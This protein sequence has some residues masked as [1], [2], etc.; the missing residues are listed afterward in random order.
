MKVSSLL[1]NELNSLQAASYGS[2]VL[3]LANCVLERQEQ[4]DA[5]REAEARRMLE[6][7]MQHDGKR[8]AEARRILGLLELQVSQNT[9]REAEAGETTTFR[10]ARGS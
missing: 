2:A 4:Q 7:Q 1:H 8:E 10:P 6:L 9:Q 3:D 5:K